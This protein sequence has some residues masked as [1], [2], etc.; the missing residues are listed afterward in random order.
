[1]VVLP[2]H[3]TQRTPSDEDAPDSLTTATGESAGGVLGGAVSE[4]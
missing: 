3:D 4:R 2:Q 1:M